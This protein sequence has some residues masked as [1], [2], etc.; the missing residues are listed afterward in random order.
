MSAVC[1]YN[2]PKLFKITNFGSVLVLHTLIISKCKS[3]ALNIYC[4][5]K[6]YKQQK[7][8]M[9]ERPILVGQT[10]V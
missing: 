4:N 3:V 7:L 8:A 5:K 1:R 10:L 6:T 9:S 2:V